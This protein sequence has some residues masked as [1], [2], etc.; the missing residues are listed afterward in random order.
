MRIYREAY[1]SFPSLMPCS[2]ISSTIKTSQL[3]KT[4]LLNYIQESRMSRP[5]TPKSKCRSRVGPTEVKPVD[6][7]SCGSSDST[8]DKTAKA[9]HRVGE[10]K[11]P[12]AEEQPWSEWVWYEEGQICYRGRKDKKGLPTLYLDQ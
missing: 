8:P 6:A 1:P 7:C 5:K 2:Q 10:H 12:P 11:E 4:H 3:N 9:K